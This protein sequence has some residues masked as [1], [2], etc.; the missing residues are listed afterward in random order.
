MDKSTKLCLL[1]LY[2][3][4][5]E[6]KKLTL[7]F[8]GCGNIVHSHVKAIRWADKNIDLCF[9]S[10]QKEKAKNYL[11]KHNGKQAF[12]SYDEAINNEE[13]D[14]IFITTPPKYHYELAKKAINNNKHVIVE[15]P[16]FFESKH[17]SELG[18]LADSKQKQLLISENYF[19]KPM[20]YKVREMLDSGIVGKPLFINLAATKLQKS[21]KD[22]R[23]DKDLTG[24]GALFEGGIHW[25]NF[26]NNLGMDITTVQGFRPIDNGELERSMQV[27]ANTS[28]GT[29]INLQYSW[30]VNTLLFGLRLSKILGTEGSITF[31]S[32]GILLIARGNKK[33]IS[34]PGLSKI[35]GFKPM[36]RDFFVSLRA[37]KQPEL[38]YQMAQKD[39][40]I[41]EAAYQSLES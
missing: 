35:T 3:A 39:L 32:N 40:E 26:M 37:G 21:K 8:L 13:V 6:N 10:R 9:A 4:Y 24:F 34:F 16:P 12:G 36:F 18:K 30:E 41:I 31:E 2:T 38:T 17:I 15:K 14:I 33:K 29:I 20:R 27:T 7:A 19:Y 5:P 22:W 25:I 28:Q 23:E 11:S 1:S